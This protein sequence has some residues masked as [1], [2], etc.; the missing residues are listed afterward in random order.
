[1]S[2]RLMREIEARH[3]SPI[4]QIRAKG[5]IASSAG[6]MITLVTPGDADDP[7][8]IESLRKAALETGIAL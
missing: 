7:A 1:M 3:E 2:Q 8:K 6:F 4:D 5:S